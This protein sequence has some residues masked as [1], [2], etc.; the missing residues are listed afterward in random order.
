MT[1]VIELR[2][3]IDSDL[4][5]LFEHQADPVA[6]AMAAFPARDRDS[7]MAHWTKIRVDEANR[8]KTILYNGEVAGTV[9]SF[10]MDGKRELGYWIGREYWGNGIATKALEE[11]LK[12][13]PTRPL[14]GYV[15]KQNIGSQRVL[16]KCGFD[17]L[18]EQG[19][20]FIFLLK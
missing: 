12:C 10:I 15:A 2:D 11:F 17:F 19:N 3:V 7:F 13:L 20:E 8:I 1:Q 18:G 9:M 14:Y 6:N 4:P 16:K 5:I